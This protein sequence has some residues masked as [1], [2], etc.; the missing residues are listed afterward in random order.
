[1]SRLWVLLVALFS[2]VASPFSTGPIAEAAPIEQ[3]DDDG[4]ADER[5][6]APAPF[7]QEARDRM[8]AARRRIEAHLT[9]LDLTPEQEAT[10][11]VDVA[12]RL[13]GNLITL[14]ESGGTT[15]ENEREVRA[16]AAA[17]ARR[18]AFAPRRDA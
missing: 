4:D 14:R 10:A 3:V 16:I 12:T 7:R 15:P 5:P 18:P 9:S 11:R 1:M 2:T 13:L 8:N 17:V 6:R